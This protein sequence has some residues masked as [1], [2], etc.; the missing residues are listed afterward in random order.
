M[1][2]TAWD[3][4]IICKNSVK[5]GY[6]EITIILNKNLDFCLFSQHSTYL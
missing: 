5:V 2:Y 6:S 3:I 4:R 1:T